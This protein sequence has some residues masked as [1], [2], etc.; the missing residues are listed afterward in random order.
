MIID[1]PA[2]IYLPM[3]TSILLGFIQLELVRFHV[4]TLVVCL[5]FIMDVA[6]K[7]VMNDGALDPI[8]SVR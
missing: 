4:C 2:S 1:T 8:I 6:Y 5:H 7:A 3:D